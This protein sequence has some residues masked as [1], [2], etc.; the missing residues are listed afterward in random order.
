M[1]INHVVEYVNQLVN[2][3]GQYGEF[4]QKNKNRA[5]RIDDTTAFAYN[6]DYLVIAHKDRIYIADEDDGCFYYSN[7]E[8][9]SI[10]TS[11]T[12]SLVQLLVEIQNYI[13]LVGIPYHYAPER[14]IRCGFALGV[15]KDNE[16]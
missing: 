9:F 11:F 8:P 14:T 4:W 12:Y 1:D 7:K 3:N 13:T 6:S 10:N 2:I 15:N 16:D 5:L